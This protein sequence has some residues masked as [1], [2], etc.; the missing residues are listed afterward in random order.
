VLGERG[1]LGEG[2]DGLAECLLMPA[3]DG[4]RDAAVAGFLAARRP[5]EEFTRQRVEG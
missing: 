1:V 2:D 4:S 5:A 3:D